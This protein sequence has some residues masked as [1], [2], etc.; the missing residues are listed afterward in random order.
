MPPAPSR[1]WPR[2]R[3]SSSTAARERRPP[4]RPS[5]GHGAPGLEV[6]RA[7]A[8]HPYPAS[9]PGRGAPRGRGASRPPWARLPFPRTRSCAMA[10]GRPSTPRRCEPCRPG[11]PDDLPV[12]RLHREGGARDLHD[13]A[14]D[15]AFR[16]RRRL[17]GGCRAR[18]GRRELQ[19][20]SPNFVESWGPPAGIH[21]AG[22]RTG[23]SP[24]RAARK[25][26]RG[27]GER[28]RRTAAPP[29]APLES[30][31]GPRSPCVGFSR[32]R[33]SHSEMS[34]SA[35]HPDRPFIWMSVVRTQS[36]GVSV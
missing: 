36:R 19:R 30:R 9:T 32:D 34:A 10:P 33:S 21:V 18:R 26:G 3:W 28:S 25:A 17:L 5:R 20:R 8:L 4:P 29:P 6:P 35:N 2:S 14:S 7:I 12:G 22:E 24:A 23:A 16:R 31:T 27:R 1:P 15:A 13:H 11:G